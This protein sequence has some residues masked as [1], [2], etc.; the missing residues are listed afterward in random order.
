MGKVYTDKEC[1]I[2]HINTNVISV[3]GKL[4]CKTCYSNKPK[5]GG[6]NSG[7]KL[8]NYLDLAYFYDNNYEDC[9][10]L[11]LVPKSHPVFSTL[12]LT[13]YPES[14]GVV[15]RSLNYIIYQNKKVVGIIGVNSPPLNYKKFNTFFGKGNELKFLNN[16][17]FKLIIT[18]RN[19]G[20]KV[21]KLFR[22]TVKEDYKKRYE[23]D[24]IGLITF[25][26]PPRTGAMYKADNWAYLG[27]TEG[28]KCHRRGDLGKWINK[29]W[30]KGTKKLIFAKKI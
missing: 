7:M 19:L 17:V 25:V 8:C 29:E 28:V 2:C 3:W 21:L 22:K 9:L 1:S 14:K 12:F 11:K 13:H 4:Y 30:S 5:K 18:E 27:I 23:E 20:T 16:N 24:L 10:G 26:E 6:G 15:G